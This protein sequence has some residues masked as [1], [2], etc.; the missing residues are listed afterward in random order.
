MNDLMFKIDEFLAISIIVIGAVQ[1]LIVYV[2]PP[3]KAVKY[4]YVGKVLN[5]LVK[6]KAGLGFKK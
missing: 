6:T 4:N 1:S 5:L 3:A 2:L